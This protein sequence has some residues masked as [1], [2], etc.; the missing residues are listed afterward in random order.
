MTVNRKNIEPAGMPPLSLGLRLKIARNAVGMTQT[1]LA[2]ILGITRPTISEWEAGLKTPRRINIL[3]WAHAT[4][5]DA[6]WLDPTYT[7]WDSNPQPIGSTLVSAFG[8]S[9]ESGVAS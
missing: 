2:K 7:P 3:A 1:D 8:T 5:S 4:G 6:R 9:V